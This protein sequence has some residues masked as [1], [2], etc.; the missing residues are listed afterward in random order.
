[1][2][3]TGFCRVPQRRLN[4][5]LEEVRVTVAFEVLNSC[6]VTD[7]LNLATVKV[8]TEWNGCAKLVLSVMRLLCCYRSGF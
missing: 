1:M 2:G 3:A 7:F 8:V 5:V 4:V 6:S